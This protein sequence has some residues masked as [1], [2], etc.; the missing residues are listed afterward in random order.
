MKKIRSIIDKKISH[1]IV[2]LIIN[3]FLLLIL[4]VLI[5]IKYGINILSRKAPIL[6]FRFA[7]E[8][9]VKKPIMNIIRI[10]KRM[11]NM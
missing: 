5:T 4:G 2:V 8:S 7:A 3:G 9:I 11:M 10:F 1:M 6:L